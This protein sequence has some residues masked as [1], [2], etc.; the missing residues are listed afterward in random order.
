MPVKDMPVRKRHGRCAGAI[1]GHEAKPT[2]GSTVTAAADVA[3]HGDGI[4]DTAVAG[5]VRAQLLRGDRPRQAHKQ[6]DHTRVPERRLGSGAPLPM[7]LPRLP[8]AATA[9]TARAACATEVCTPCGHLRVNTRGRGRHRGER[10]RLGLLTA[11]D[12]L[13]KALAYQVPGEVPGRRSRGPDGNG[14]LPQPIAVQAAAAATLEARLRMA[15]HQPD[16]PRRRP[17]PVL[18][19][20]AGAGAAAAASAGS[21]A[22]PSHRHRSRTAAAARRGRRHHRCRW[23]CPV[24]P[25]AALAEKVF[26]AIP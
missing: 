6:L 1:E 8:S 17:P 5:E 3:R 4:D 2:R 13:C 18:P 20:G 15:V 7:R 11:L 26:Q 22:L 23:A 12:T 21:G 16:G 24:V 10:R 9:A 19:A 14:L 25:S